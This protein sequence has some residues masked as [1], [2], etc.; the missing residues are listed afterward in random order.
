MRLI[1][2]SNSVPRR[3]LSTQPSAPARMALGSSTSEFSALIN[4]ILVRGNSRRRTV[5]TSRPLMPGMITSRRIRSGRSSLALRIASTPFRASPQTTHS[6]QSS[7]RDRIPCPT[8]SLSSTI[9]MRN[10]PT[11]RFLF[12]QDSSEPAQRNLF[13]RCRPNS[14]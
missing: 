1:A 10:R 9:R 13:K 5:A 14:L 7:K 3:P 8:D 4:R 6:G 11:F 12:D 2:G